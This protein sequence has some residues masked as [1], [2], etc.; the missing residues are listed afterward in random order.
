[1]SQKYLARR[2]GY[3]NGRYIEFEINYK[4]III[5]RKLFKVEKK[6][7]MFKNTLCTYNSI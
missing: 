3:H 4:P 7:I 5:P 6:L 1:M 2:V